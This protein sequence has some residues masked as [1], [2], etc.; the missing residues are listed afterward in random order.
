MWERGSVAAGGADAAPRTRKCL[1]APMTRNIFARSG[2]LACATHVVNTAAGTWLCKRIGSSIRSNLQCSPVTYTR[3]RGEV[4]VSCTPAVTPPSPVPGAGTEADA[5]PTCRSGPRASGYTAC[6]AR[7]MRPEH[8]R[9]LLQGLVLRLWNVARDEQ[10]CQQRGASKQQECGTIPK[11]PNNRQQELVRD[12]RR[13]PKG[14]H[15]YAHARPSSLNPHHSVHTRKHSNSA[16]HTA[17]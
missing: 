9:Y 10:Q 5:A 6:T 12:E 14:C 15:G 8:E 17:N 3:A 13:E 16:S 2:Q 7:T 4:A 11:P 1:T